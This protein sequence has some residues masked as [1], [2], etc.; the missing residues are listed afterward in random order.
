MRLASTQRYL[1]VLR[2]SVL[3]GFET[4]WFAQ[5]A[6]GTGLNSGYSWRTQQASPQPLSYDILSQLR[7]FS[8]HPESSFGARAPASVANYAVLL[9]QKFASDLIPASCRKVGLLMLRRACRIRHLICSSSGVGQPRV[10][11]VHAGGEV[12]R[13]LDVRYCCGRAAV[14][15]WIAA[16]AIGIV[17][18]AMTGTFLPS[19]PF[20][21]IVRPSPLISCTYTAGT[22]GECRVRDFPTAGEG[23]F[24]LSGKAVVPD[25]IAY[26]IR[27]T[28]SP[29]TRSCPPGTGVDALGMRL[30]PCLIYRQ[31]PMMTAH[32]WKLPLDQAIW[33]R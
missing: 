30:K 3:L 14:A 33:W 20:D 29:W 18:R 31:R 21:T 7:K 22:S 6:Y 25:V 32:A 5:Q 23:G 17:V 8:L 10:E 13:T 15:P 16:K 27:K 24:R 28:T 26:L 11:E 19:R 12:Y 2:G 1:V 4:V 9:E